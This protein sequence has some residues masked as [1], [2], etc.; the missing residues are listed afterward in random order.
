MNPVVGGA[1]ISGI[2]LETRVDY[3]FESWVKVTP[4]LYDILVA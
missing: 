1:Q 2:G 3:G 4:I